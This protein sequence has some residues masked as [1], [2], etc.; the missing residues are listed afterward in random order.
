MTS[1]IPTIDPNASGSD[2]DDSDFAASDSYGSEYDSSSSEHPTFGPES[3]GAT[4]QNQE[5]LASGDE[6]IVES[7]ERKRKRKRKRKGKGKGKER[8]DAG[9][10]G[11]EDGKDDEEEGVGARLRRRRDGLAER[12]IIHNGR[13]GRLRLL[14]TSLVATESRIRKYWE[15]PKLLPST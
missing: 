4:G 7:G 13:D 6:G 14:L 2:T 1:H 11:D 3:K 9:D 12:Y 8:K 15:P 10:V 5:A